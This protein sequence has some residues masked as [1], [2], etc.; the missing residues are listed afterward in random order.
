MSVLRDHGKTWSARRG[1]SAANETSLF[2]WPTAGASGKIDVVWYQASYRNTTQTPDNYPI[3]AK[4]FV[5]FAQNLNATSATST[6]TNSTASPAVHLGGVCRGGVAC[7]GDNTHNRDLYDDFGVAASPVTGKAS[8]I[9]SIDQF[10]NTAAVPH[11][12]SC[13]EADNNDGPC[14][15]TQIATQTSGSGIF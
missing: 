3:T 13:T 2:P 11:S 14:D 12:S 10:T 4:W 8:I 6:F 5:H 9:Y 1:I 7:T 15:H